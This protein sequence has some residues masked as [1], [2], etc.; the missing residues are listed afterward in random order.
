MKKYHYED[1]S[2]IEN[3][4]NLII[5]KA[6]SKEQVKELT[7]KLNSGCGF[8]GETPRFFTIPLVCA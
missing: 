7:L 8:D 6:K 2:I 4:T 3:L 5:F 1:L